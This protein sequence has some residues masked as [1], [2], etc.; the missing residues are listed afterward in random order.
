MQVPFKEFMNKLG[1]A[2]PLQPYETCPWSVY[3]DEKG[4]TCSAEARMDGEG[5]QVEAEIQLFYDVPPAGKPP[6]EQV[7]LI[8]ARQLSGGDWAV[9]AFLV[10]GEVYGKDIYNWEEKSCAF[11]KAA[12][13]ELGHDVIPDF[14]DILARELNA[15]RGG[16]QRGGGG[17]RSFKSKNQSALLGMKKGGGGI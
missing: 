6:M 3:E 13:T 17:G 2:Q 15:E 4:L 1:V 12:I 11:F 9:Y 7:C 16:D 10:R 14:D 8:R 5:R